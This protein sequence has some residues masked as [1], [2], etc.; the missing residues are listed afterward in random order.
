MVVP[1]GALFGSTRAHR[2]LRE[3]LLREFELP[4]GGLATGR[5]LQ[6]LRRGQD[7][8]HRLPPPVVEPAEGQ[9]ATGHVWF[10]EIRND[11]Y[12]PDKIQSGGR[13]ETPEKNDIRWPALGVGRVQGVALP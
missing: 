13:P 1:E 9:A 6:T 8:R 10:Y 11:G 2:E 4:G 3:K 12:N 5:G 7:L